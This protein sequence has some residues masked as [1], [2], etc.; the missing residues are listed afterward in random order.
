MDRSGGRAGCVCWL[1]WSCAFNADGWREA[2]I[3]GDEC[4]EGSIDW[5]MSA[6]RA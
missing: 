6:A 4:G 1:N 5:R 2:L 3:E